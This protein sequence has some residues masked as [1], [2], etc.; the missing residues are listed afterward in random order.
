MSISE[1]GMFRILTFWM[2]ELSP[3]Q[4]IWKANI[5][6][7]LDQIFLLSMPLNLTKINCITLQIRSKA[8][9]MSKSQNIWQQIILLCTTVMQCYA[10]DPRFELF[11]GD[12]VTGVFDLCLIYLPFGNL[13]VKSRHLFLCWYV[14]MIYFVMMRLF[15]IY[16]SY[17][18][19]SAN[20]IC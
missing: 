20:K 11:R 16:L 4:V 2:K 7:F 15:I 6:E 19:T 8:E 17:C 14:L 12:W 9:F 13:A 5:V 1:T 3:L 10:R 18:Q